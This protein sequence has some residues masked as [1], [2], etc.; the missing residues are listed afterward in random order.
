MI[1][2][3]TDL[4]LTII[5]PI[6]FVFCILLVAF[7]I[8]Y[9]KCCSNKKKF[10]EDTELL[11]TN[12]YFEYNKYNYENKNNEYKSFFYKTDVNLIEKVKIEKLKKTSESRDAAFVFLQFFMRSNPNRL[13]KSIEHLPNIGT[14]K[15]RNWFLIKE[16]I[17]SDKNYL[18][19]ILIDIFEKSNKS[20][21]LLK[22]AESM[23][24]SRR[25][26]E[27][28]IKD[29]FFSLNHPNV[30][31]QEIHLNFDKNTILI[32][33]DY[34]LE[35]SLKYI[36][37]NFKSNEERNGKTQKVSAKNLF[38]IMSIKHFGKQ[39]LSGLIYLQ[40]KM[41][42]PIYNLHSGNIILNSNKSICLI[43]GYENCLFNQNNNLKEDTFK[44]MLNKY[45]IK[46]NDTEG[47]ILIR[48]AK[49]ENEIKRLF[50]VLMYGYL[51]L[52]MCTGLDVIEDLLEKDVI[53]KLVMN[54]QNSNKYSN[55]LLNF[56]NFIFFNKNGPNELKQRKKYILPNLEDILMHEFFQ[57]IKIFHQDISEENNNSIDISHIELM[58]YL[59]GLLKIKDKK[60]KKKENYQK[61]SSFLFSNKGDN[62]SKN[63]NL[64]NSYLN[65]EK[66]AIS[67]ISHESLSSILTSS[68]VSPVVATSIKKSNN[69]A[70]GTDRQSLL[71]DIRTGSKLRKAVTNDRSM[72]VI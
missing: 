20:D 55:E 68:L 5:L 29:F 11:I 42:P 10:S 23:S 12:K 61:N 64:E 51:I 60:Q 44:K 32:I 72:P 56:I 69:V 47:N 18:K 36:V 9:C 15:N 24:K 16:I 4:I 43:T 66:S 48:K 27:I 2:S 39:I 19:M 25:E 21:N 58:K 34:S 41:I 53:I 33:Q 17:S 6:I 46:V 3:D 26:M 8:F 35:G 62:L 13:F 14:N 49:T 63:T 7:F 71:S 28:L 22:I 67:E 38:Y 1:L 40:K 30:L 45:L 59:N 31:K 57:G 65:V 70:I 54:Y 52:E 37:C 50:E